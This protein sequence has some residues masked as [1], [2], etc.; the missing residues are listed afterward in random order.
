MSANILGVRPLVGAQNIDY[1]SDVRTKVH[2]FCRFLETTP[3]SLS[4][5][6]G[7]MGFPSLAAGPAGACGWHGEGHPD[8]MQ[9]YQ[10]WMTNNN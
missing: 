5:G 2:P 10:V 6:T 3:D 8:N 4:L 1:H 7:S 9:L